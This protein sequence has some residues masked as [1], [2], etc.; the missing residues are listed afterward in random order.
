LAV[1]FE[2]LGTALEATTGAC[3][4]LAGAGV[5]ARD[6]LWS[7]AIARPAVEDEDEDDAVVAAGAITP[8]AADVVTSPGWLEATR[9]WRSWRIAAETLPGWVLLGVI[10]TAVDPAAAVDVEAAVVGEIGLT[11]TVPELAGAVV[12]LAA[13]VAAGVLGELMLWLVAVMVS[14]GAES[15]LAGTWLPTLEVEPDDEAVG[16][17]AGAE[18]EDVVPLLALKRV[19]T[20]PMSLSALS[21]WLTPN[22][23]GEMPLYRL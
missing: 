16:V 7:P 20:G 10:G 3:P 23:A 12:E 17:A 1:T 9:A 22:W 19:K 5:V 6:L 18:V 11:V 4:L 14:P 13:G 15:E 8:G 21:P 2:G